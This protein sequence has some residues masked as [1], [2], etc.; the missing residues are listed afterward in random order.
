LALPD[1]RWRGERALGVF[2]VAAAFVL[3]SFLVPTRFVRPA[4]DG[5]LDVS[6]DVARLDE[7]VQILE[8]E[9]VLEEQ[10]AQAVRERLEQVRE[11]AKGQD[12]AKTWEALDHLAD[13]VE[14]DAQEA[15]QEAI[16]ETE[17]LT[18]TQTLAEALQN[19][20]DQLSPEQMAEAMA[21]LSE[22][23]QAAAAEN[24]ALQSSLSPA[25]QQALKNGGLSKEQL[26][27]L[28]QALQG[29]KMGIENSLSRMVDVKLIEAKLLGQC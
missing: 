7:Q 2:G 22:L 26:A 15:A 5:G 4:A 10:E 14:Q 29:R 12:P 21:A 11:E 13:R 3:A 28:N 1:L 20:G 16:R 24:A 19:D 25:L 8:E 6:A 17:S 27:Q 23:A 18:E 9:A